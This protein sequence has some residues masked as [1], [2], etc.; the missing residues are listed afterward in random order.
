M[1]KLLKL[2]TREY[3]TILTVLFLVFIKYNQPDSLF[4]Y[5]CFMHKTEFD[6]NYALGNSFPL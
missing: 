6:W 4:T 5:I 3:I 2:E 1:K